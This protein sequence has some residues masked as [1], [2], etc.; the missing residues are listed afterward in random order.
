MFL[1]VYSGICSLC[2]PPPFFFI[3]PLQMCC[4]FDNGVVFTVNLHKNWCKHSWGIFRH[5]KILQD[6]IYHFQ[7]RSFF[8]L[9]FK[10]KFVYI[11]LFYKWF[12][13]P[14]HFVHL[15]LN[16]NFRKGSW[17]FPLKLFRQYFT[18]R[19]VIVSFGFI[20]YIYIVKN[21]VYL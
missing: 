1:F 17:T 6:S 14:F 19:F 10:S 5:H 4:S 2:P 8:F 20:Y 21:L 15:W 12:N 18:D 16:W 7:D 11:K 9:L 13:L 3:L